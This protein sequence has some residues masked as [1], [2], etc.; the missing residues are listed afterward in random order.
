M[1]RIN[2]AEN[3]A[4]EGVT[5]ETTDKDCEHFRKW[6]V[7][8]TKA[9][10]PLFLDNIPREEQIKIVGAFAV[11]IRHNQFG[12]KPLSQL[13]GDTVEATLDSVCKTFNAN[14]LPSPQL[15]LNGRKAVQIERQLKGYKDDDEPVKRQPA[16]P[17][18]FFL[19]INSLLCFNERECAI[20]DLILIAFFFLMRSCEYSE[21]PKKENKRTKLIELRDVTFV[22]NGREVSW[23]GNIDNASEVLITFRNQKNGKKM[24]T[25]SQSRTDL[26]LCPCKVMIRLV[27]RLRNHKETNDT[28]QLNT[29]YFNGRVGFVRNTDIN[30]KLK[31]TVTT[32]GKDDLGIESNEVGTHSL[33]ASFALMLALMGEPDSRIMILGRWKSEAF[34]KYIERQIVRVRDTTASRALTAITSNFRIKMR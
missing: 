33:R 19:L 7:F 11:E 24:E 1:D 4:F 20:R 28:T 3:D 15:G 27:K 8:T 34:K 13:K 6:R 18:R 10:L 2:R 32:M 26:D 25:I 23:K 31:S 22:V 30:N 12:K 9:R 21:T 29:Y 14:G 16:L 17:V 5:K